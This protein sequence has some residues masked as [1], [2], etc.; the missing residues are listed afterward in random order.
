M[1]RKIKVYGMRMHTP[2][3]IQLDQARHV[4]QC[5][6][7]VTATS[8]AQAAERLGVSL[9]SFR[10]YG[11]EYRTPHIVE[12]AMA[13][14]GTVVYFPCNTV[15]SDPPVYGPSLL[16][17]R[18]R[19]AQEAASRLISPDASPAAVRDIMDRV[20]VATTPTVP[21]YGAPV[22]VGKDWHESMTQRARQAREEAGL[23]PDALPGG[24][25]LVDNQLADTSTDEE[26]AAAL[27]A[28]QD[29]VPPP[30]PQERPYTVVPFQDSE[31]ATW[32]PAAVFPGHL[33]EWLGDGREA[34]VRYIWV[35]EGQD[36]WAEAE[37]VCLRIEH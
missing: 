3:G 22:T 27:A 4:S 34:T 5:T 16:E 2:S 6:A 8:Q 24:E 11:G 32:H 35:E 12:A 7:A 1:P 30:A 36:V 14:R 13:R 23:D 19:E 17:G 31:W 20:A 28:I 25:H 15:A 37:A 9:Y 18:V 26:L 33:E 21:G 10:Q 29:E